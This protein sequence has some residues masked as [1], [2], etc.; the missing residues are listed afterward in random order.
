MLQFYYAENTG[1]IIQLRI[2]EFDSLDANFRKTLDKA[3]GILK[4]EE[5]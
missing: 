3:G 4:V 2:V 5:R 1:D